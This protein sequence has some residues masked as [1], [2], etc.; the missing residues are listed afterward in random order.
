MDKVAFLDQLNK[1]ADGS[2]WRQVGRHLSSPG[3]SWWSDWKQMAEAL[4]Y[5]VSEKEGRLRL[6]LELEPTLYAPCLTD[7]ADVESTVA[8]RPGFCLEDLLA[9]DMVGPMLPW[10][11]N[12]LFRQHWTRMGA[13]RRRERFRF[14]NQMLLNAGADDRVPDEE[15][16][17]DLAVNLAGLLYPSQVEAIFDK[18]KDGGR[19][20]TYK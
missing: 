19:M 1:L 8:R 16:R 7:H 9:L 17:L 14:W 18:A 20:F 15:V 4:L 10:L 11:A 12:R 2:T 3:G 13:R 6:L 5:G